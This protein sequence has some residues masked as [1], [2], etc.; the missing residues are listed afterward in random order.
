MKDRKY[1]SAWIFYCSQ[2]SSHL[3]TSL[4]TSSLDD[5]HSSAAYALSNSY[6]SRNAG[7]NENGNNNT[8]MTTHGRRVKHTLHRLEKQQDEFYQL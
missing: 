1:E 3:F 8:P 2:N 6:H 7:Y 4:E 5:A